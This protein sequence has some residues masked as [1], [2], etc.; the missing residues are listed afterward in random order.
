[1]VNAVPADAETANAAT[2]LN[3]AVH[4]LSVPAAAQSSAAMQESSDANS[5]CVQHVR[6]PQMHAGTLQPQQQHEQVT[7]QQQQQQTAPKGSKTAW[8]NDLQQLIGLRGLTIRHHQ[9]QKMLH[10]PM[11]SLPTSLESL[12]AFGLVLGTPTGA[13]AVAGGVDGCGADDLKA[14]CSWH[15]SSEPSGNA[16]QLKNAGAACPGLL[17]LHCTACTF[18]T[19]STLQVIS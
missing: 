15:S 6:S 1:M 8:H 5:T 2:D 13:Y 9:Q 17:K 18:Y 16:E 12:E 19:P 11:Q 3:N 10:V 4:V 7:Q 14:E